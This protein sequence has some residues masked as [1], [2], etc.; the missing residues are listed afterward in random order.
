MKIKITMF[1][2]LAFFIHGCGEQAPP[3]NANQKPD[4]ST[5]AE[6]CTVE[7]PDDAKNKDRKPS[8]TSTS[9]TSTTAKTLQIN[10]KTPMVTPASTSGGTVDSVMNY[11]T[12]ATALSIKKRSTEKLKNIQDSHNAATQKALKDN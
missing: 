7:D 2:L 8:H 10:A 5:L 3:Q 6:K 9:R 4:Y 11:G 12:G 1:L